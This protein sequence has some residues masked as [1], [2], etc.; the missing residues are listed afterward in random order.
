MPS[1]RLKV[2]LFIYVCCKYLLQ[3]LSLCQVSRV[4]L[5]GAQ[6]LVLGSAHYLHL[7]FC[8]KCALPLLQIEKL[9]SIDYS[10]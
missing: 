8:F 2:N 6:W 3:T 10:D 7:P 4:G 5:Q 9:N 1:K